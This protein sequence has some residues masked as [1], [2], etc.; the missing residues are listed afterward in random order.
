MPLG[1]RTLTL[2]ALAAP[3]AS[4]RVARAQ[5]RSITFAGYSGIFQENYQAAVINPF[6]AAH[7]DIRVNYFALP[8]SAQILGTLRAQKSSPQVDVAVMDV[9]IAK[10]GTDEMLFDPMDEA[11]MPVLAQLAPGAFT[12]GVAGAA[13]TFDNLVLM[14][15]PQAVKPPPTSW[16][17]LWDKA[18]AN[19]IAI[20]G[21]PDI[22]GVSMVLIANKMFGGGDYRQGVEKGIEAMSEM[23][24]DVLSWAP[25]PDGYSFII[26]GQSELGVGWNARGQLYSA[27]SE[28]K[29]AVVLPDEGSL[30]QI[31][32]VELVRGAR[33]PE[34]ARSFIEY[35]L[36][37]AAQA[38]FTDRM[39]YA[40]TNTHAKPGADALARTAASPE[41]RAKMLD[42]D[43]LEV[44][45]VR[46][47]I[48][49]QWRRQVM[50]RR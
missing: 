20:T 50:T 31:N 23:A 46:D 10:A 32:M 18:Y 25:K 40:P 37:P 5:A 43:W 11:I 24:P 27:Q 7:P 35:V 29:L 1:R 14:Y 47:R 45:K 34:A 42:V 44:A 13:M 22:I 4:P 28:G 38:A 2:A 36:S 9:S 39:F 17:V 16:K 3:L 21:V 26:N 12:P 30:F 19:Q 6:M 33:Q 41:R 8:S 49:E 15:A 48:T